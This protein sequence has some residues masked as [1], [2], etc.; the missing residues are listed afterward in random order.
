M[1]KENRIVPYIEINEKLWKQIKPELLDYGYVIDQD[2]TSGTRKADKAYLVIDSCGK[3]YNLGIYGTIIP[4]KNRI[5]IKDIDDFLNICKRLITERKDIKQEI[6]K[7]NLKTSMTPCIKCNKELWAYIKPYLIK[8]GYKTDSF[9][10]Q[11]N[12]QC[13][14]LILN[15]SH[16]IGYYGFGS[17]THLDDENRILI[18][19]VD[20]FLERAATLQGFTYKRKSIMKINGIEIKPGMVLIGTDKDKEPMTVI[21]F[22]IETGIAFVSVNPKYCWS[23]DYKF[24]ID[25]ILEIRDISNGKCIISGKILWKKEDTIHLTKKQIAEKLGIKVEQLTIDEDE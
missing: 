16:K 5:L 22:P 23:K 10:E 21:A 2:Y 19:N 3:E 13:S 20:E 17:T 8:W 9:V 7:P 6:H 15:W 12:K 14:I 1:E 24:F 25:D 4:K 18:D 11:F